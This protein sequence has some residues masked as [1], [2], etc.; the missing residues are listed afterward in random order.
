[1][2]PVEIRVEGHLDERWSEWLDGFV[3]T[4]TEDGQTILIGPAGDQSALYG[5][6]AKLRDLS[7]RLVSVSYQKG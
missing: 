1:M 6:I 2:K 4:H 3:I 5:L 7:I